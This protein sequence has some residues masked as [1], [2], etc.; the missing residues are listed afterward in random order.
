MQCRRCKKEIPLESKFCMY[1]GTKQEIPQSHRSR[2]NGQGTAYK[3]GKTW[4]AAWTES[5]YV[6]DDGKRHQKRITKG[7]FTSKTAA[8]NFAMN[9]IVVEK[10]ER[11][12]TLTDYYNTYL[13]TGYTKLSKSKQVATDIAWR[14]MKTLHNVPIKDLTID[15]LQAC[16]DEETETYYPAKDM[17]TLF[18]HTYKRAAAEGR[19]ASNISEYIQLPPLNETEQT[20]FNASEIER[21]WKSYDEGNQLIPYVLLMIYTGMM[22]GELMKCTVG[23]INLETHEIMGCALKTKK[24]KSTPIIYPDWFSPVVEKLVENLRPTDKVL[25]YTRHLFYKNYHETLKSIGVRDLTPY[26]CRHTTATALALA[27]TAPSLIQ[28]IMRHTKFSTTQ[29][30]IHPDMQAAHDAINVLQ[31]KS[32]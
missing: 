14:K 30:Y 10:Q 20:P 28:E 3:R 11:D 13:S 18:S 22:P 1:C 23:M 12:P 8:L 19:V 16:I 31:E 5:I 27:K 17:K 7:G 26:S 32:L 9:R 29:R 4:T 24:R 25:T 15:N 2:G 21:M 6:D